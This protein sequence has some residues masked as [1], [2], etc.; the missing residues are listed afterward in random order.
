MFFLAATLVGWIDFVYRKVAVKNTSTWP[1]L[2]LLAEVPPHFL[3]LQ[4]RSHFHATCCLVHSYCTLGMIGVGSPDGA[5]GRGDRQR[6]PDAFPG[7]LRTAIASSSWQSVDSMVMARPKRRVVARRWQRGGGRKAVHDWRSAPGCQTGESPTTSR[8]DGHETAAM[9]GS[10]TSRGK[11][12]LFTPFPAV[13]QLLPVLQIHFQSHA[14]IYT[15]FISLLYGI[16]RHSAL[17]LALFQILPVPEFY[18]RSNTRD[19]KWNANK[20]SFTSASDYIPPV[21]L[22]SIFTRFRTNRVQNGG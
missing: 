11:G 18:F 12:R 7:R 2:S 19:Q 20:S 6:P 13:S 14:D 8:T 1:F 3:S 10:S 9:A 21:S 5:R 16:L 15:H 17:S 4:A 22:E